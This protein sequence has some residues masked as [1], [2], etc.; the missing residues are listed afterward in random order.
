MK[1]L[2]KTTKPWTFEEYKKN[3][4]MLI[5]TKQ[6]DNLKLQENY[7]DICNN[8][9]I[10]D[11]YIAKSGQISQD[12]T[13][14]SQSAY[15]QS[16]KNKYA[17][18]LPIQILDDENFVC[19]S[20]KNISKVISSES[21]YLNTMTLDQIKKIN[22]NDK[23]EKILTLEESLEIIANKTQIIIEINNENMNLKYEEKLLSIIQKYINKYNCVNNVAI[24]SINP[25]SLEYFFE[26]YPY[27]TRILKSGNFSEKTYGSFK[28]SKLKKLKYY[29]ITKA[30][31]IAYS[32]ELLP[33]MKV[34]NKKPVGVL[35]YTITNQSQYIQLAPHCDN[36]IFSYF[37]PT[38]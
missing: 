21:G 17:I 16:I 32:Q 33:S 31:F 15:E 25:Y 11:K 38:I 19:F 26:N 24:M 6:I 30:D 3:I 34:E 29:K 9:W 5:E 10:V 23:K 1:N 8:Y 20:H 18:L 37:K 2:I 14:N 4:D 12:V 13:P 36:I 7:F 35:A 28:T 27:I 22:L